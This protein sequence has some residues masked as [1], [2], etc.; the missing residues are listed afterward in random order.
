VITALYHFADERKMSVAHLVLGLVK[1]AIL[2]ARVMTTAGISEGL[3]YFQ[4]FGAST[5]K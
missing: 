2:A 1:A 5:T 4:V 3:A